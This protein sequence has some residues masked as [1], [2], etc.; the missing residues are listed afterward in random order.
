MFLH[1]LKQRGLRLWGGP[2]DLVREE[3]VRE[4]R[5]LHEPKDAPSGRP[6]LLDHLSAR[7]IRGHQIRRELDPAELQIQHL[8]QRIDQQRLGQSRHPDD[9]A[10]PSGQ[11]GDQQLFDK[12]LLPDDHLRELIADRPPG[13]PQFLH[14]LEFSLLHVH[15]LQKSEVRSQKSE[16]GFC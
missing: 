6:I 3:D 1:S 14:H 13:V 12:L 4:H 5:P 11:Q 10:M 15:L 7:D 9:Q 16:P 8:P 2:V